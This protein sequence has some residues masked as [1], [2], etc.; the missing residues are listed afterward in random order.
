MLVI[1]FQRHRHSGNLKVWHT[2]IFSSRHFS[3]T[4]VVGSRDAYASKKSQWRVLIK[5][6]DCFLRK[7]RE[8]EC[9]V[10]NCGKC[11]HFSQGVRICTLN[12]HFLTF[13]INSRAFPRI[14]SRSR[15]V[16]SPD[17]FQARGQEHAQSW[18][19][20]VSLKS[21]DFN[22]YDVMRFQSKQQQQ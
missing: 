20:S 15:N 21:S 1:P 8:K 5:D 16:S 13:S 10:L 6:Y 12:L 14:K 17:C 3:V 4:L 2:D 19:R 11:H 7:K 18:L 22:F 9:C